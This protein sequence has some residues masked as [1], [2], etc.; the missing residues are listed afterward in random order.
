MAGE[1]F[2]KSTAPLLCALTA[3]LI[4]CGTLAPSRLVL[5]D[6]ST[7]GRYVGSVV[8]NQEGS[9]TASVEVNGVTFIGKFEA[10]KA[11]AAA[12]LVGTGGDMLRCALHL[13]PTAR[14]GTGEC[15]RA[16]SQRFNVT[17]SN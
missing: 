13:D 15:L 6:R 16:G 7:G 5:V 2:M 10:S 12:V 17:L 11:N 14:S 8:P 3:V 4:G 1:V 9:M